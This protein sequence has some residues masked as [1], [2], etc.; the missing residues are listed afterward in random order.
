MRRKKILVNLNLNSRSY[1]K[2]M[3]PLQVAMREAAR[4]VYMKG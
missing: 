1:P 2:K 3:L 4:K